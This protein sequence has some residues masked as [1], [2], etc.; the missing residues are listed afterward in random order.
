MISELSIE[1]MRK[2]LDD[3]NL[4]W[5]PVPLTT[6]KELRER[7]PLSDGGVATVYN[8]RESVKKILRGDDQRKLL[9]VGPC[10]I[11]DI[12][13]AKEY[14]RAIKSLAESVQDQFLVI[15]RTYLEK[16]RTEQGWPGLMY[17][18]NLN[19]SFDIDQGLIWSRKLLCDIAELG[20]P[21]ATETLEPLPIQYISDLPSWTCIGARTVESQP[22]RKLASALSTPVGVK[23][24]TSGDLEGAVNALKVIQRPNSFIGM[25][26]DGRYSKVDTT[27]NLYCHIILRGGQNGKPFTNYD[28][29]SVERAQRKL[30]ENGLPQRLVI[31]CSHGNALSEGKKNYQRQID[32]FRDVIGQIVRGNAGIIGLMLESNISEG[33]Q[34]VPSGIKSLE[35]L[36]YGVSITDPCISLEVTR[37]LVMEGCR[38]L[39]DYRTGK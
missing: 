30:E 39:R 38:M 7:Y 15:M 16:P 12:D 18:P 22:H 6:P 31:D 20:L 5:P 3:A 19:G 4:R 23:N 9:I 37:E 32:V 29:E 13:A 26:M 8:G 27:G 17:D 28:E 14:A 1:K 33:S 24:G 25:D 34:K 36:R 11:H 10:S 35:E 21:T 2:S